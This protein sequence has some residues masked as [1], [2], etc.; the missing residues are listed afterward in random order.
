MKKLFL[1]LFIG[2][3][4][5]TTMFAQHGRNKR[6]FMW[7]DCEENFKRTSYPDSIF[8]YL[9]KLKKLGFTDVVV[10]VKSIMG[11]TLFKSSY[12]PYMKDWKG[13]TRKDGYDLLS[14]FIRKAKMVEIKVHASL[15][16]FSGGHNFFDRGIIYGDHAD[17]QSINYLAQGLTPI[18][19][20][21]WH[22][23]G[24]LNPAL[25]EVQEYELNIIKEVV[26]NYPG[27]DG[28]VLDRARYDGITSDFSLRSKQ[29]FEKYAGTTV[30]NFPD[31]I[32]YW[33]KDENGKDVWKRGRYFTQWIEWRASVIYNFFRK[34]RE[35]IKGINPN[36]GFSDYTGSWYPLYYELGVNWASSTY[37]PSLE[38]D[39]AT[40]KYKDYAYGELL[41]T[42]MSGLYYYEVTKEE[43]A[44]ANDESMDKHSEAGMSAAREYWYS[45]EGAAEIANKVIKGCVPLYGSL[46]AEQ[47]KAN[48]SQFKKAVAMAL[49]KT[50]GLMVYDIGNIIDQKWWGVLEE[51]LASSQNPGTRKISI[52]EYRDKVAG[53][54]AGKMIGV[55]YGL[56]CEFKYVDSTFNGMLAWKP[57]SVKEALCND[58]LYVQLGFMDVMDSLGMD[59][60]AGHFAAQ[61]ANAKFELC[62]AN[63]MARRNYWQGI[64]PPMSG[65]PANNMHADD[66]DFQIESDFIGFI[67]PGM[68][69]SSNAL[70][71]KIGHIMCYGDGVYGGMFMAAMHSSAFFD[72]DIESV[73][74]QAL[75]AIPA[76]SQYAQCIRDVITGYQKYPD[77][78]RKTWKT[79][80]EKWGKTDIC[81]PNHSFN[82]DA[83]MNGAYVVLALLY[84]NGDFGKTMEIASRCGQDTDCNASNAAGLLGVIKG[85]SAIDE[86]WKK[87]IPGIADQPFVFTHY[88]FHKAIDRSLYYAKQNILK[89]GGQVIDS[90][91]I[92]KVQEPQ[93]L[94]APEESFPGIHYSY[95]TTVMQPNWTFKGKWADFVIGRGDSDIFKCSTT[96]GDE[97]QMT[98]T[99]KAILLQG[100]CNNDGGKA[101][102]FIDNTLMKTIDFY[103]REE[104]GIYLGNR[105]HLFHV[106]TL[107]NKEHILR[108]VTRTDRN[109]K[110][111]G[112]KVWVERAMIYN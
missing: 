50:D 93:F 44:N 64:M 32:L 87:E 30:E 53:G 80:T 103:Y 66:I 41:D 16:V 105:A 27:L 24:M 51:A 68:P 86:Y 82:I 74:A 91:L 61:L 21:K 94:F 63:R 77:D 102:I 59:C 4:L 22:Y 71:N 19:S 90:M 9:E 23:D 31:D 26:R 36:I 5:A 37:D 83:K 11:E 67:N 20:M 3:I 8:Y 42:Y 48:A 99:G 106:L 81:V 97:M 35:E 55:M 25:P 17:W 98:F 34:T 33:Q 111:S 54:W 43:V 92:V 57:E 76:K 62:H 109:S 7:F 60:P 95:Q 14:E 45:V 70:C 28:I 39:W 15:N 104:A 85:Y 38:Y 12:A 112:H 2:C 89:N 49:K 18:T 58:D 40:P 88:T 73:V 107:D 101:D 6:M 78:W 75:K 29:L 1:I 65:N 69:V 10:D 47:Y 110:S 52:A 79:V 108:L 100:Y 96:A 56:P 13:F 72:T 46:Y 84:G